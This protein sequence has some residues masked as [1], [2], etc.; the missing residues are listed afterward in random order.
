VALTSKLLP[1]SITSRAEFDSAI[2]ESVRQ[3]AAADF[4][5][6]GTR[7][8]RS[9]PDRP[10]AAPYAAGTTRLSDIRNLFYYQPIGV[11]VATGAELLKVDEA[12]AKQ[13]GLR[14]HPAAERATIHPGRSYRIALTADQVGRFVGTTHFAP[15]TYRVIDVTVAD[16]LRQFGISNQSA[17]KP[18]AR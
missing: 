18:R 6:A 13:P 12:L 8:R 14:L 10:E 1:E 3:A 11:L 7:Q 2:A 17:V 15:R 9:V 16:A 5:V 4:A